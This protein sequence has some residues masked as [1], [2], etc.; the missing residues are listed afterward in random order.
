MTSQK[1]TSLKIGRDYF[2]GWAKIFDQVFFWGG[3][4]VSVSWQ[5]KP[6]SWILLA[7]NST[8][9]TLPFAGLQHMQQCQV[10]FL[11]NFKFPCFD[12]S[13]WCMKNGLLS[14][15]SNP[16]PLGHVSSALTTWPRRLA[17]NIWPS[18]IKGYNKVTKIAEP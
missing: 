8:M 11:S 13:E 14:W 10:I 4:L 18:M 7:D 17:L 5:A 12:S 6:W 15:D 2:C 9:S 3:T 1:T 16:R